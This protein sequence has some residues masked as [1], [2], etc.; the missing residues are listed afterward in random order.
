MR[1]T[2][3]RSRWRWLAR[4]GQMGAA[5]L[6]GEKRELQTRGGEG[7]GQTSISFSKKSRPS[8]RWVTILRSRQEVAIT[9]SGC[10]YALARGARS[11]LGLASKVGAG[12]QQLDT[13]LEG[14]DGQAAHFRAQV[15]TV[16]ANVQLEAK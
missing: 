15:G 7:L 1:R 12:P 6:S 2:L 13:H 3:P 11:E 8:W 10:C 4:A 5:V 16:D 9:L 14:S